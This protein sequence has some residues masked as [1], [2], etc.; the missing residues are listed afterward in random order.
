[1]GNAKVSYSTLSDD[2]LAE[3]SAQGDDRAFNELA[4]RY[5]G[6]IGFI[7][8][9]YSARGYDHTDFVQEGLLGLFRAACTYRPGSGG[10]FGSYA[11]LVAERRFISIIRRQNAQRAVPDTAIVNLDTLESGF[12]DTARTPEEELMLSEQLNQLY[13][14]LRQTLSKREFAVLG[15]YIDGLAYQQI[16]ARMG[17]SS[18]AVDNALQRV[19]RKV[20]SFD[21]S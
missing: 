18:K 15:L 3:F 9:K 5:L 2:T 11:M 17:I 6:K 16:A 10:S 21:M 19:R 13:A 8:R 1:M 20:G 7:A 4:L 14:R 12:A